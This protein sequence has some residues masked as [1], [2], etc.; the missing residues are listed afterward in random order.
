MT[1]RVP[2]GRTITAV[3]YC[4]FLLKMR[5]KM[6]ANRTDLLENGVLILHATLGPTLV[7]M[8]VNCWTDTAGRCCP[9]RPTA[10]T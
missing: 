3:Y 10:P 1:D 5:R 8:S 6:H 7:R 4:Q 9:I 2:S